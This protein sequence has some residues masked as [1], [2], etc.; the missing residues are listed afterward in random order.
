[1]LNI[2]IIYNEKLDAHKK[3]VKSAESKKHDIF[4]FLSEIIITKHHDKRQHHL[5]QAEVHQ[6][7]D[8]ASRMRLFSTH[9]LQEEKYADAEK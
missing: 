6:L 8:G 4:M 1:M 2:Y 5:K 7:G 3:K 9:P